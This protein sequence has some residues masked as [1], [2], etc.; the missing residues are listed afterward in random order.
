MYVGRLYYCT[1]KRNGSALHIRTAGRH[2]HIPVLEYT[3]SK[4]KRDPSPFSLSNFFREEKGKNPSFFLSSLLTL[5]TSSLAI[6][7]PRHHFHLF[8][9]FFLSELRGRE[10]EEEEEGE[11]FPHLLFIFVLL[12]LSHTPTD[13]QT[14]QILLDYVLLRIIIFPYVA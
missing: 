5:L 13:R 9:S 11:K 6:S 14:G 4:L 2:K 7:S 12:L 1:D 10:E 3:R 8:L